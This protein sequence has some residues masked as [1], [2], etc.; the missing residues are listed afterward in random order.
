MDY[1]NNLNRFFAIDT[2]IK[3]EMY[4][5]CPSD[6]YLDSDS[7]TK[8]VDDLNESL[9]YIFN[10]LKYILSDCFLSS[11][12]Q[13]MEK[14]VSFEKKTLEKF[15]SCGL[16]INKL[17]IFYRD[18]ISDMRMEFVDD[19]KKSC[20]GY[21]FCSLGPVYK[22]VTVNEMLHGFHY[23]FLNNE[24]IF[25]Q[26]GVNGEKYN[27]YD[28]TIDLRGVD[29]LVAKEIFDKFPLDFNCGYT[30]IVSIN[31]KKILM[32]IRD[33]GHALSIEIT[34]NGDKARVEY[35]VPKICNV[36][37]ANKLDGVNKVNIDSVGIT[38]VFECSVDELTDKLFNF[39]YKV[40]TDSDY[41]LNGEFVGLR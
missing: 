36:E 28:F 19:V 20:V 15:Y 35:F 12:P 16:D 32:M 30:D 6:S 31:D 10:K 11:D 21:G 22:A 39:I 9:I 27:E 23:Y 4:K 40:P 37:K 33:L 13:M 25:E 18:Y 17:K 38:G 1:L 7:L 3:K 8:Y 34:L 5:M 26:I 29:N 2:D 14:I 41:Y 24:K